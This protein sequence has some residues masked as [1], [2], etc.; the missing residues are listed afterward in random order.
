VTHTFS[1]DTEVVNTDVG[2][3]SPPS[4][5]RRTVLTAIV[6]AAVAGTGGAA[7]YAAPDQS[8]RTRHQSWHP[9][10]APTSDGQHPGMA[11]PPDNSLHGEFVTPT[12]DGGYRTTLVQT[13]IITA[14][15]PGSIT[16]RSADG[17]TQT[18]AVPPAAMP[19][20][21]SFAVDQA[22]TV[23]ATREGRSATITAIGFADP[24]AA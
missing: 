2:P 1:G 4:G 3:E 21:A 23:R 15:A 18:Y 14:I 17:Y 6:V 8:P 12:P 10:S 7:I 16:A 20:S 22:V 13:G 5:L 19:G 24:T 9:P 11:A